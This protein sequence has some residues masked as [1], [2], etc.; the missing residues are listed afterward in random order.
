MTKITESNRSIINIFQA[1]HNADFGILECVYDIS[2][3]LDGIEGVETNEL[4]IFF[5]FKDGSLEYK[6]SI[7]LDISK[8]I[9]SNK[10][11][12]Q[13]MEISYLWRDLK[14]RVE[15]HNGN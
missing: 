5:S 11:C 6:D 8:E 12:M 7:S 3:T 10:V 9:D 13:I 2:F 14:L 1:L 4:N 15:Q